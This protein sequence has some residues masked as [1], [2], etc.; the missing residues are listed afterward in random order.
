MLSTDITA[1]LILSTC[2]QLFHKY[3]LTLLCYQQTSLLHRPCQRVVSSFTN[4]ALLCY[5]INRHHCCIDPVNVWSALS[6]ILPYSVMLSTDITAALILSTCGQ[7]FH[8][9]C[10]T[11]L[12]YQQTSLLHRPC[13]RV[14]SSFTNIALLC[15]VINRHHCCIDPV[16]VWSALSQILPYSVM[17]S[18]D[19]TAALTLSTCGQLFHKYCLTLLCYQQ[20]SLLH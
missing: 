2:G 15:Y 8:K 5:V 13:Q 1:A 14:V 6:Q 4:I 9:Y 20:T 17:L 11:L 12:C 3:C 16:N 18:T 19:I 10:L 7:L